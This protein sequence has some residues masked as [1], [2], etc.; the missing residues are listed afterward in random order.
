MNLNAQIHM[1]G[2]FA[3]S[4]QGNLVTLGVQRI[5]NFN[6]IFS[7]SGTLAIQL[8]ATA[9]PYNG[10]GILTGHKIAEVSIGQLQGGFFFSNLFRTT[11][12]N[13]PPAGTYNIVF[14]LAEWNGF[15]YLTD[16]SGNFLTFQSFGA[17]ITVPSILTPPQNITLTA[18][19]SGTMTVSISGSLP[20]AY[21]WLKNGSAIAG[22]TSATLNFVNAQTADAGS[23]SVV[24]SNGAGSATS[25]N[26][27]LTVNAVV[28]APMIATQPTSQ[29][30]TAGSNVT[31]SV[32][33]NGS[34]PF[35]YQWRKD[36]AA[37]SGATGATLPLNNMQSA[38]AGSYTV[39]VTNPAGGTTSDPAMVGVTSTSKVIGTGAE[40][41]SNQFVAFNNNTF[42][43]VALQGAAA[44]ITADPLQITRMSFVDLNDDIVQ[45]E[46]SGAGSLS[47]VLDV[48]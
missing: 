10:I 31:L 25:T 4:A 11:T 30:V 21:Q 20:V 5:D 37:I 34:A 12:I 44:T 45:V 36:G 3:Y 19:Q 42:D 23:Y 6:S 22:A 24:V 15:Q 9:V 41:L 8:W 35:S 32:L 47:L 38:A 39:V 48:R 27:T 14:I 16:D 13:S 7:I 18:G 40:I 33:T 26:A 28:M 29:S 43:Q 1:S 17:V 46:F 2:T